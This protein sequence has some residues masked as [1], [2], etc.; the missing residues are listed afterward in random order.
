M[1]YFEP[2]QSGVPWHA[3]FEHIEGHHMNNTNA[4]MQQDLVRH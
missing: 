4:P 2:W 3:Q 1:E